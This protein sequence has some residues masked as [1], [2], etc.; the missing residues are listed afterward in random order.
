MTTLQAVGW[1][2]AMSGLVG[3]GIHSLTM[4]LARSRRWR[5]VAEVPAESTSSK[6]LA[7]DRISSGS[8]GA[9]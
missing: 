5:A 1:M 8:I 7:K 3:Q 2:P 4:P 6:V 9:A